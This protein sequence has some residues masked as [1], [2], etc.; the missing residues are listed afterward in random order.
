MNKTAIAALAALVLWARPASAQEWQRLD[1][2]AITS[3]LSDARVTYEGAWQDFR[4]SGRTLYN[5]G[6]DSWGRWEARGDRYCSQWPP[7]AGWACYDVDRAGDLIRF[8][9]DSGDVTEGRLE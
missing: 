6:R 7:A 9:G 4:A 8:T 3:A 2:E 5:A 1:T